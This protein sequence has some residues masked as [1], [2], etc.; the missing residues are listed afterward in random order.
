MSE[1]WR[2]AELAGDL[3]VEALRDE[4]LAGHTTMG[5]GGP[6]PW[7]FL[8]ESATQAAALF[9]ELRGGPLPVKALG[10][11][12]NLLVSDD[13]V[14]AA[15]VGTRRLV[16]EPRPL[17]AARLEV[18]AGAAVP[19]LVRWSAREGLAGLE[20]AEGIPAQLGG[21]LR[22]NAG[23][24]DSWFGDHVIEVL[25]A[26]PDGQVE[27]YRPETGDFAYRTSF[28]A[29]GGRLALGA[30]LQLREDEPEA[31]KA[32]L[33]PFK[34]RRRSTQPIRDRSCGCVFANYP[35]AKIGALVEQLGLKGLRIGG[36]EVSPVHGNF[37]V[38][39]EGARA[40][41]V[42]ALLD[43]MRTELTRATGQAPRLE[44]ELWGIEL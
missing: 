7:L 42:L 18:L 4:P 20:F 11:G 39:R 15:V 25:L 12:S 21:A 2:Y 44:V 30:V 24:N 26:G 37:V 35:D 8:P 33:R 32:R 16:H 31:I 41:D 40:A 22:M 38:N 6:V 19:G 27:R 10:N 29:T 1:R 5:V 17:G 14:A 13:G 3:G 23:A 34:Q 9:A 36:A 43:R 28:I